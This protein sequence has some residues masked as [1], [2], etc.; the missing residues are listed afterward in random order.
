MFMRVDKIY[1]VNDH[2]YF[3]KGWAISVFENK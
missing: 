3:R 1:Q 2:M